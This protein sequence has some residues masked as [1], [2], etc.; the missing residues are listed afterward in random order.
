VRIY[1]FFKNYKKNIKKL[2]KQK[3]K[4]KQP[5]GDT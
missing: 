5:H 4:S 1:I 3:N 2:K